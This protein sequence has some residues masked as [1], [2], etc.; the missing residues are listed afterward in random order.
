MKFL[1]SNNSDLEW[2]RSEDEILKFFI[3]KHGFVKWK[4]ISFFFKNKNSEICKKRWKLWLNSQIIKFKWEIEQD[5][6][7]VFFFFFSFQR[8]RLFLFF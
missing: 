8:I 3:N 1:S 5:V 6:K 7:L 4:K 2:A